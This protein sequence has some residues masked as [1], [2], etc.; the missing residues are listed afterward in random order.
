MGKDI[1]SAQYNFSPDELAYIQNN[2]I[3]L[4]HDQT[5]S[6]SAGGAYTFNPDS[7]TPTRVSADLLVQ[8]G[9]RASTATIPNGVA[10]PTYATVNLS[11][12]QQLRPG[13]QLRLDILNVADA[14]YR[15]SQRHRRRRRR[16]AV[17][18]PADN[19]GGDHAAVLMVLAACADG[20]RPANRV[21]RRDA[22]QTTGLAPPSMLIAVPVVKPAWSLHRKQAMAANSS[23]LPIRPIG[24]LA[25]ILAANS[26]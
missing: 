3:H 4:D 26:S 23:A 19:P 24:T 21:T 5:W 9:L 10:L 13:T 16:A 2:Y 20:A 7:R 22:P 12:V 17:W 14:T 1:N 15:D 8:S 18:H 11:A 6:G 25:P